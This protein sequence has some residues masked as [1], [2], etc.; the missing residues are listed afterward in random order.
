MKRIPQ[1]LRG[2]FWS[3]N[4]FS[5]DLQ[6]DKNYIIHQTLMYGSLKHIDWLRS[7]YGYPTTTDQYAQTGAPTNGRR[8]LVISF[9]LK[10]L[11]ILTFFIRIQG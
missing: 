10:G 9:V 7:A 5:L 3:K 6:Q 1:D 2:V 11:K 4:V 8:N